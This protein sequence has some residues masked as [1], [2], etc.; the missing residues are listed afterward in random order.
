MIVINKTGNLAGKRAINHFEGQTHENNSYVC[1][2]PVK[3]DLISQVGVGAVFT[4]KQFQQIKIR[5]KR[6]SAK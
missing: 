2:Y 6:V 1:K 5:I 4:T 3:N